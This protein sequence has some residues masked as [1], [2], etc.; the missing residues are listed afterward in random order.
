MKF[1]KVLVCNR[2]G[3]NLGVSC[4]SIFLSERLNNIEQEKH[5]IVG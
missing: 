3:M 4:F 2:K 5:V 1:E